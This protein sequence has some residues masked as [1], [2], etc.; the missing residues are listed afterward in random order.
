[1]KTLLVNPWSLQKFNVIII[2]NVSLGYLAAALQNKGHEVEILDC[3]KSKIDAATFEKYIA[4]NQF[5]LIGFSLFTPYMGA[6]KQYSQAVKR[7]NK[8]IITIVGGPHAV[9]EPIETLEILQDIDFSFLGEAEN[10]LCQLIDILQ[11]DHKSGYFD[12]LSVVDNLVW[13]NKEN[14]IVCN[15]RVIIEDLDSL[16]YPAWN[17][18]NP[19]SY[20]LAPIGIFSRKKKIAPIIATRGCPYPCSFCAAGKMSGK[21]IRIRSAENIIGEIQFLIFNYQVEEI[22]IIDDNFT[23]NRKLVEDFCNSLIDNNLNISWSCPNGIRLDTLD[24]ELL[25]LMEESGCYSFGIGIEFGTKKMLDHV[26]KCL[27]LETIKEKVSLIKRTTKIRITGFFILGHPN[28]TIEDIESTIN[29]ACE[30]ELDRA[31]FFNFSPFPGTDD[32]EDLIKSGKAYDSCYD[33]LFINNVIYTPE[34]I[35]RE[36]LVRL[37]K[38]AFRRFFMRPKILWNILR[39]IRSFSQFK[40]LCIKVLRLFFVPE[41]L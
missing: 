10:G 7:I 18:M 22:N 5:Q 25:M 29:F 28:E 16:A 3:V 35:S 37:Q 21:K 26:Q 8:D 32:Y 17:L 36:T 41:L 12:K 11:C 38:K 2:P 15:P 20:P 39:E 1:M 19:N 27:T 13:R 6:V 34:N 30:L 23:K 24:A 31:N 40:V 9:L 33:S 4:Q 14:S